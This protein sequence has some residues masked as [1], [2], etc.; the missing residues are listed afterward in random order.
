MAKSTTEAHDVLA[1]LLLDVAK[2]IN[3]ALA[4]LDSGTPEAGADGPALGT[5]YASW[6]IKKLREELIERGYRDDDV[7]AAPK[8]EL[9]QTLEAD[10]S[11]SDDT[12]A[13]SDSDDEDED[14]DEPDE[15]S[16]D[17]EEDEGYTEDDLNA[18]SKDELLAI[19][20]ENEIDPSGTTKKKLV[21]SILEWQESA[22]EETDDED[23]EAE[24]D[25]VE[26]EDVLDEDA[27]NAMSLA[28]VKKVA[29]EYG[30]KVA[31]GANQ[32]DIVAAILESQADEEGDED[33]EEEE[34]DE[35]EMT[36]ESMMAMSLKDL[37][38]YAKS[39]GWT[40]AELKGADK[41]SI[42]DYYFSDEPDF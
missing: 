6:S 13:D 27:L 25:E 22:E 35:G 15:D 23:D 20:E 21:A 38:A 17:E 10:D 2:L 11:D 28:E 37:K 26:D 24:E 19:V 33:E 16:E 7:K 14:E 40:A 4:D 3:T 12:D 42:V 8:A 30:V 5:D 32:D 29:K 9:I 31:K 39:D 1:S 34:S 41:D 18:L 36:R